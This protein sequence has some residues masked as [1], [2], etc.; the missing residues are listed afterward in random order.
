MPA[1]DPRNAGVRGGAYAIPELC[2][3]M[4]KMPQADELML[5]F[6]DLVPKETT[7]RTGEVESVHSTIDRPIANA[8]VLQHFF[9]CVWFPCPGRT[10]R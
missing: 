6:G 7:L 2:H 3:M 8:P 5:Y 1:S 4:L 10:V 9:L